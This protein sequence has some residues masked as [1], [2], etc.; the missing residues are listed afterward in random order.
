MY[1]DPMGD[2][3]EQIFDEFR[4]G[5]FRRPNPQFHFNGGMWSGPCTLRWATSC[6][7]AIYPGNE[8]WGF[9]SEDNKRLP[10]IARSGGF[11]WPQVHSSDRP[12]LQQIRRAALPHAMVEG[13]V[14]RDY[15]FHPFLP[16]Q[17]LRQSVWLDA[18]DDMEAMELVLTFGA[19]R[20]SD[21]SDSTGQGL[22]L[23]IGDFEK[24]LADLNA[25]PPEPAESK[26]PEN[27]AGASTLASVVTVPPGA[28]R[29]NA[30]NW[31]ELHQ[32]SKTLL[33]APCVPAV[34]EPYIAPLWAETEDVVRP[35][36]V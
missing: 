36:R 18:V 10:V 8:R 1:L 17:A 11:Y 32:K 28:F 31:I 15:L 6:A 2:H 9:K 19:S 13:D 27:T 20:V 23:R 30:V 35:P 25:W 16:G 5:L 7:H 29:P 3:G 12:A 24:S 34:M 4:N 22:L 33:Y 21:F 14:Q 26:G